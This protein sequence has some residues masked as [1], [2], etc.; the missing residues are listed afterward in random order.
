MRTNL[1]VIEARENWIPSGYF[2]TLEALNEL[3]QHISIDGHPAATGRGSTTPKI[4]FVGEALGQNEEIQRKPFVGAAGQVLDALLREAGFDE[5]TPYYI[6]NAVKIRPIDEN[7]QNRAP[8]VWEVW[9][10]EP[11]LREEIRLL[12]PAI[13][14]PLGLVPSAFFLNE[15]REEF[16]MGDVHGKLFEWEKRKVMPTYH[17]ASTLYRPEMR[18]VLLADLKRIYDLLR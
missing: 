8:T 2:N 4:L 10:W 7:G 18:P 9:F 13:I 14:V 17:P 3:I 15:A 1:D 5:R 12:N 16:R 6:T 11:I